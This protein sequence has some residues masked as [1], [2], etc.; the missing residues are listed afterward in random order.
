MPVAVIRRRSDSAAIATDTRIRNALSPERRQVLGLAVA[1]LVVAVGRP[2]RHPHRVQ[3]QQ[4]GDQVGARVDRLGDERR[5]S[6]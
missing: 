4:R 3:G 5:A 2:D 1:V 6:R